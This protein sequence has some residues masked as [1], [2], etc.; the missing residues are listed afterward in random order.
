MGDRSRPLRPTSPEARPT[1]SHLLRSRRE[2]RTAA[3]MV[4]AGEGDP[5]DVLL[6]LGDNVYPSGD[7]TR[8][9]ETVFGPFQSVLDDGAKLLAI[10][11]NHDVMDG[12][13]D[14]QVAA[15]GLPGR[16]Y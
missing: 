3:A 11:G 13:A 10:L 8:L 15:L 2:R 4:T 12:H 5:Y 16:W 1:P 14:A 6:L 7:P 9:P